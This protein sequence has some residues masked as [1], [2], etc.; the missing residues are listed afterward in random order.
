VQ[1]DEKLREILDAL[2]LVEDFFSIKGQELAENGEPVRDESIELLL[3][4]LR[5]ELDRS[6]TRLS[7]FADTLSRCVEKGKL[8]KLDGVVKSGDTAL[9]ELTGTINGFLDSV[10][11]QRSSAKAR[12]R[13]IGNIFIIYA[14]VFGVSSILLPSSSAESGV[15]TTPDGSPQNG[16]LS[17]LLP[18]VKALFLSRLPF[19]R[20]TLFGVAFTFT[21]YLVYESLTR[22]LALQ[23]RA[24]LLLR[25]E[26]AASRASEQLKKS[27]GYGE[28]YTPKDDKGRLEFFVIQNLDS[29]YT[30][31]L[32][33]RMIVARDCDKIRQAVERIRDLIPRAEEWIEKG[34]G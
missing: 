16:T 17:R 21:T 8:D 18:S 1:L 23:Q 6:L 13:R 12:K 30:F 25:H 29:R 34:R 2:N 31:E 32:E 7:N 9:G 19:N 26:L 11:T 27:S 20:L 4:Q 15:S 33:G 10:K 28:T 22:Q 24:E 3:R 14:V 5:S